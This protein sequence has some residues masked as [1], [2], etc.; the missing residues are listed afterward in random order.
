MK[1]VAVLS[2]LTGLVAL[3]VAAPAN[4]NC[5]V[6][7]TW[8]KGDKIMTCDN[9]A[10]S[11]VSEKCPKDETC[12]SPGRS[13]PHCARKDGAVV[14]SQCEAGAVYC[15]GNFLMICGSDR[16]LT[17]D[18]CGA[19]SEICSAPARSAP[20]C[21][22][23]QQEE[24]PEEE[25]NN[26]VT[27]IEPDA[28]FCFDDRVMSCSTD[29]TSI[30]VEDC[31]AN[32]EY[33]VL[34]NRSA[35][36]CSATK[37]WINPIPAEPENNDYVCEP[38]MTFCLDEQVFECGQDRSHNLIEDCNVNQE[39]CVSPGKSMPHCSKTKKWIDPIFVPE[40]Q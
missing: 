22:L 5:K 4:D 33:C 27:C 29:R 37:V 9:K 19:R 12:V 14:N 26:A 1:T 23:P 2:A 32:N 36:H 25:T 40:E 10:R 28:I 18:D 15:D 20:H 21:S 38:G 13:F 17:M 24:Q 31:S 30:M 16:T 7:A 39:F 3:T 6:G 35:P 11:T 34:P 8:C